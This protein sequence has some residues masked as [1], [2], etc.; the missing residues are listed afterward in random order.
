ML[1]ANLKLELD[2]C[3]L[4]SAFQS[5]FSLSIEVHGPIDDHLDFL[6]DFRLIFTLEH[7]LDRFSFPFSKNILLFPFLGLL[8]IEPMV[9]LLY[10]SRQRR[11]A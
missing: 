6:L 3:H 2:R 5:L 8:A 10:R 4:L 7:I 9:L 1:D 11:V